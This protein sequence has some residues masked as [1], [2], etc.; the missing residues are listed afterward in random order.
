MSQKSVLI[1]PNP[2][3]IETKGSLVKALGCLAAP[4]GSSTAGWWGAGWWGGVL[5]T[6]GGGGL[7]TGYRASILGTGPLYPV[8]GPKPGN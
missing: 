7:G 6:G 3:P 5:G 2:Q 8:I 4:H 1:V